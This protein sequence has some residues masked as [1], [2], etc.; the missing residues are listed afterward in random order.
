MLVENYTEVNAKTIDRWVEKGWEWGIPISAEVR[1]KARCGEWDVVLTPLRS[2]PKDWFPSLKGVDLL[3]LASGGGQQMPVF[4]LQGANC[5]VMDLSD[6][7]LENERMVSERE[8][9]SIAIV[10]GDMT[11]RFPFEDGSF[12]MIFHPVSN[13]FVEDVYHIWNECYRVLRPGGILLA[14]M[15]NGVNFLFDSY[16]RPLTVTNTLPFNPLKNPE[17]MKKLQGGNDGIQF[18]HTFDEQIGG[19]IKA[20]FVITGA[21]E[22]YNNDQDAIADGIPAYWATRAIKM[23]VEGGR[24]G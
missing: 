2:V 10:K 14:G 16:E 13:C 9:Y 1:E 20:G 18:S 8:G 11:R 4:A 3:G 19:Q 17:Q 12:D 23:Q 15:D 21:Y 7:Q 6:R 24:L 22:D 5:T